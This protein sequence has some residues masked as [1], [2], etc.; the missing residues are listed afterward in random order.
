MK[1]ATRVAMLV[2]WAGGASAWAHD[3]FFRAPRYVLAPG[4]SVVIDVLSGTFSRSEN[5]VSR[6]RLAELVVAGPGGRRLLDLEQ[7]TEKDPKS[8]L[9]VAFADGGGTY[10]V[11]AVIRP[12]LLK[13]SGKEFTAYLKE[14]GLEDVVAARAAQKRHDEPSRE[15]YSKYLKA[16]FQLGDA[17]E[18]A[19]SALGHSAEIIPERSPYRLG[20]GD[21]LPVR[22]L[23]DGQPWARKV[24]FAGGRRGIADQ[25]FP[26]QRLL[27]DDEGRATVQIAGAG[28]WYVKLVA[29]REV[30][31]AEANYESKWATLS[32][33]V[34]PP[35]R[36][37]RPSP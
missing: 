8:T 15:R 7:W 13:L 19:P 34:A 31:D 11:G 18:A 10:V 9:R 16:V 1:Q 28:V 22:C 29:M 21:R 35:S 27:T 20:P 36:A 26:P 25:R 30:K 24:V 14:E 6:D 2:L 17:V 32:F 4:S 33:A 37:A 5:A 23:V 12:R 3:L